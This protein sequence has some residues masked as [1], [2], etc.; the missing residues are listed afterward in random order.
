MLV[1]PAVYDGLTQFL[2]LRESDNTLRFVTGLMGGIGL[3][4]IIKAIKWYVYLLF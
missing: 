1:V 3:G 2:G 4:V